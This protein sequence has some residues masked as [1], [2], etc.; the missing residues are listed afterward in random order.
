MSGDQRGLLQVSGICFVLNKA[1]LASR[2]NGEGFKGTPR[3]TVRSRIL[4]SAF[5]AEGV[6]QKKEFAQKDSAAPCQM[7]EP[8]V[9]CHIASLALAFP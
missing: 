3:S 4:Q 5:E 6:K 1:N 2:E 9:F 7:G 8:S